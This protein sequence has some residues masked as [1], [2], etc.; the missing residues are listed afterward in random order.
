MLLHA[1]RIDDAEGCAKKSKG[2]VD[3]KAFE[4]VFCEGYSKW[5]TDDC[6]MQTLENLNGSTTRTIVHPDGHQTQLE[7]HE[8]NHE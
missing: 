8:S 6:S 7:Y 3:S 5:A 4:N 1:E 2:T